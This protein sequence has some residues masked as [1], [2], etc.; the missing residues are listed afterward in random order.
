MSFLERNKFMMESFSKA[1]SKTLQEKDVSISEV[2][3][4]KLDINCG[5]YSRNTCKKC[6]QDKHLVSDDEWADLETNRNVPDDVKSRV[7][8]A[9]YGVGKP[10]FTPN[11]LGPCYGKCVPSECTKCLEVFLGKNL[12][13]ESPRTEDTNALITNLGAAAGEYTRDH[14]PNENGPCYAVCACTAK[15]IT[16]NNFVVFKSATK[17]E[18][19]DPRADIIAET[20]KKDM[21]KKFED[22]WEPGFTK[23]IQQLVIKVSEHATANINQ[24]IASIS[25]VVIQGKGSVRAVDVTIVMDAIMKA[26]VTNNSA[27]NGFANLTD[28]L[29]NKIKNNIDNQMKTTFQYVWENVKNTVFVLIGVV[30][31][32][33][34]VN[35]YIYI[36]GAATKRTILDTSPRRS[37]VPATVQ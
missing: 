24:S 37:R 34:L 17:I 13:E 1:Y 29:M 20:V 12:L 4:S 14:P 2:V 8:D 23:S 22:D 32:F 26:V 9:G 19:G 6:L 15:D 33:I 27:V 10:G 30:L 21:E 28:Q 36:T 7:E 3:R 25:S 31:L 16:F 11:P 35:S 5:G 18:M